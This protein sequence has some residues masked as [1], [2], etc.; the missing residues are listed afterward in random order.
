MA[1]R[2]TGIRNTKYGGVGGAQERD[3]RKHEAAG[4]YLRLGLQ[5]AFWHVPLPRLASAGCFSFL[6]LHLFKYDWALDIFL[7]GFCSVG[8]CLNNMRSEERPHTKTS[9][10]YVTAKR[11]DISSRKKEGKKTT[12]LLLV[13]NS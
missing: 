1:T 12:I 8:R 9:F 2:G 7:F 10:L 3:T 6:L 5:H 11:L 13:H 4:D